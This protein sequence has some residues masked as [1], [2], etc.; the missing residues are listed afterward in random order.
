MRTSPIL[1]GA[2]CLLL[3]CGPP[4]KAEGPVSPGLFEQVLSLKGAERRVQ[5]QNFLIR[6]RNE[7]G[8]HDKPPPPQ[9]LALVPKIVRALEAAPNDTGFRAI[10]IHA[11]GE[12]AHPRATAVLVRLAARSRR[13]EEL[14]HL[15]RALAVP[16][17]EPARQ[18]LARLTR[19]PG[20]PRLRAE[21]ALALAR[22][23]DRRSLPT[24]IGC[25]QDSDMRVRWSAAFGLARYLRNPA[26]RDILHRML[27]RLYLLHHIP[28]DEP[29]RD[30]TASRIIV[31]AA[32]ALAWI[33]DESAR[34]PLRQALLRDPD[35][36]VRHACREAL[37]II[38]RPPRK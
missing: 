7:R 26:G 18:A 14:I 36:Q 31:S 2:A 30:E 22:C 27:D 12:L 5:A 32:R 10:L 11:L 25:L 9:L 28:E 8:P 16:G 6:L 38:L 37:A 35:P 23:E 21:A 4:T 15:A 34:E 13:E 24:L 33:L 3:G 1:G 17:S 20:F 19:R 29:G